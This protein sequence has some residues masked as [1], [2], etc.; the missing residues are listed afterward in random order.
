[1]KVNIRVDVKETGSEGVDWIH[2]AHDR[3]QWRDLVNTVMNIRVSWNAGNFLTSWVTTGFSRPLLQR[4]G[5]P[6][7]YNKFYYLL[8]MLTS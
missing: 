7:M 6:N 2:L 4:V 3:D 1:M 8:V 5:R